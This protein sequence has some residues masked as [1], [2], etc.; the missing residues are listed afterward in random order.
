MTI[1]QQILKKVGDLSTILIGNGKPE[2][3]VVFRL[4]ELEKSVAGFAKKL[5]SHED[6]PTIKKWL[7]FITPKHMDMLWKWFIRLLNLSLIAFAMYIMNRL[8]SETLQS[9]MRIW[10]K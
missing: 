8:D 1:Q 6:K 9:I 5:I 3:S 10:L 7:G 4:R 2:D